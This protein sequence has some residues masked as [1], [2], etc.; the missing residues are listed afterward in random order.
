MPHPIFMHF[1]LRNPAIAVEG[2]R[3]GWLQIYPAMVR[4]KHRYV[5]GKCHWRDRDVAR[6]SFTQSVLFEQIKSSLANNFGDFHYGRIV[7][8][9]SLV[10]KYF[11]PLTGVFLVRCFREDAHRVGFSLSTILLLD[12]ERCKVETVHIGG[13][14]RSCLKTL[15]KHHEKATAMEKKKISLLS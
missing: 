2:T 5:V 10:V 11:N 4:I 6:D 8:S 15:L 14:I 12:T 7:C 9:G 1:C 3:N 13:T